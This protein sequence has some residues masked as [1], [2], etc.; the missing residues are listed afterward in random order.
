MREGRGAEGHEG[1]GGEG[2]KAQQGPWE[3]EAEGGTMPPFGSL[4]KPHKTKTPKEKG[5]G[6]RGTS[7]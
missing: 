5:L 2:E 7:L 3:E 4:G 1:R 6:G